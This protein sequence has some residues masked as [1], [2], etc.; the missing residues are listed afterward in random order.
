MF[1]Q[2]DL[3]HTLIE[4]SYV[5][6]TSWMSASKVTKSQSM[7]HNCHDIPGIESLKWKRKYL[8]HLTFKIVDT[9]H[10]IVLKIGVHDD[11]VIYL[12]SL[13]GTSR[14]IAH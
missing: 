14:K 12:R 10:T 11:D 8:E 13:I 5:V 6:S 2:H 7:V 9:N 3:E 1:F 4:D